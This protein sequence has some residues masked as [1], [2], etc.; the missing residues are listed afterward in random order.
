MQNN[1]NLLRMQIALGTPHDLAAFWRQI[2]NLMFQ[3]SS[4][5]LLYMYIHALKEFM[6]VA[7]TQNIQHPA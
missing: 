2:A 7:V 4:L 3:G 5:A 6:L 1:C